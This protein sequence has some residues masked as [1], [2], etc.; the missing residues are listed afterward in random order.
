MYRCLMKYKQSVSQECQEQLTRRQQLI[1]EDFKADGGLVRSCKHEIKEFSCKKVVDKNSN[2]GVKLS[3]ILL[4]LEENIRDGHSVGGQCLNEMREIRREMMEDYNISPE[5]V[6]NCGSEIDDHCADT[7]TQMK[8]QTIHCLM[9]LATEQTD[10]K[11][12]GDK[13]EKALEDLLRQTQVTPFT[14]TYGVFQKSLM[15]QLIPT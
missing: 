14:Y 11:K 15:L 2:N 1:A 9:K 4:C 5:L 12:I 7:K 8:G 10:H 6:A 13:C 3:Q